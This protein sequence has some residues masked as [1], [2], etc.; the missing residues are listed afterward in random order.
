M[1]RVN[2]R[3]V[4]SL[5]TGVLYVVALSTFRTPWFLAASLGIIA[6]ELWIQRATEI[7]WRVFRPNLDER[8]EEL[9]NRILA[10]SYRLV[11]TAVLVAMVFLAAFGW[12][13]GAPGRVDFPGEFA[14]LVTRVMAVV[15]VLLF[16]LPGH[17]SAWLEPTAEERHVEPLGA[18]R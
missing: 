7:G 8:Q 16:L 12:Y 15:L 14:A 9:Q 1:T 17:V 11:M 18:E 2:R 3:R 10:I 13:L 6:L 5:V 4:A